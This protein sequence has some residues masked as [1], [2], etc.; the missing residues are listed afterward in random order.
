MLAFP[1]SVSFFQQR[2]VMRTILPLH[3]IIAC[4]AIAVCTALCLADDPA[5][6]DAAS[7][8][9]EQPQGI[10]PVPDYSG[11]LWSRPYLTGDWGSARTDLAEKGIQFSV[12]WTQTY[13][14]VVDGGRTRQ[15][16]YGGSLDYNLTLDLMR[17]GVLPGAL[18]RV[19]AES[20]Y[21]NSVNGI[22]GPILPVNTDAFFPLTSS[23]D[24]DI[25]ITVTDLTYI[26]FLSEHF[27]VVLGKVD[28]LDGDP[29]EF[30]SGRGVTQ[31]MN[32]NFIFNPVTALT[33]PYSSLGAGVIVMP[34]KN[35]TITSMVLNTTDASTTTGFS[36]F[37]DGWTWST[38]ADFQYRLGELPGGMN[39][40]FIYAADNRF[41][42]LGSGKFVFQPGEGLSF[43]TD[44]R[45]D[46]WA[47]Y[48]SGWQYLWVEDPNDAPLD[49]TNRQ[50]DHQGIGLFAR[51]GFA[52]KNTNPIKW[53]VAGGVGGRGI[54]PS[55]D[56]DTFG[57]GYFYT[58]LQSTRFS[59]LLNV[60]DNTKGFEAFYNIAITPAAHLTFDVQVIDSTFS[61]IDTAVILGTRLGLAF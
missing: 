29:N 1:D 47:V 4:A 59:T 34:M 51:V 31:F 32:S 49:L 16:E 55:R 38:E 6:A 57:I 33:I 11:D 60:A 14:H 18:V 39:V 58:E 45:D 25:P 7:S 37:G 13:Q 12:D 56:N 54:I 40:S 21:G 22:A 44:A 2:S 23:L 61:G 5:N 15:G 48:L 42:E 17:M 36:N 35:I 27:G 10:L 41:A 24:E 53:T 30:A 28:T 43:A 9:A 46:T 50:P 26:Q 3:L 19:R 20:R 52:D 8:D